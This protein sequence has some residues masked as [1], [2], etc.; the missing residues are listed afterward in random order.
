MRFIHPSRCNVGLAIPC[1]GIVLLAVA[2]CGKTGK[3]FHGSVVC[4]TEKVKIGQVTFM[5]IEG[6]TGPAYIAPIQNGEYRI[7]TPGGVP[8]GKYRV[9]VE[10]R[11]TTGRKVP[12][13]SGREMTM[14]DEEVLVG[15]AVYTGQQSPLVVEVRSNSSDTFDIAL[16]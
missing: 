16:R 13:N 9:Q 7:T 14:I 11:K 10:A 4:G 8:S 12:G 3:A 15:P 1:V 5:P 6:T 2:G